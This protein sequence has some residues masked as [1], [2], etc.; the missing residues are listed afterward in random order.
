MSADRPL[1]GI[2]LMLCFCVLA[3]L[4]DSMAKLLGGTIPLGELIFFRFAVQGF[5]L[6]PLALLLGKSLRL[7]AKIYR[8]I[9]YRTVAHVVGLA[10]MF[11]AL[12]YLPLADAVAIAFV[13]PFFIL[14]SGWMFL[15]EEVGPHRLSACLVG[16]GGTLLVIQPNFTEVGWPAFLPLIVAIAFAAFMLT[17]RT[18]A[19]EVD[20]VTMQGI[21]GLMALPIVAVAI[22]LLRPAPVAEIIPPPRD[23]WWLLAAFGLV[24][25]FSHFFMTWSLKFAPA[26]TLAPMQYLEIPFSTF[27]GWL[28]FGDLPDGLAGLGIVILVS[29]GLYIIARERAIAVRPVPPAPPAS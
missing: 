12:Q 14:L 29:A 3:P 15:G 21:S 8:G 9:F 11:A 25:T 27:F 22:L 20:A 10:A 6:L 4:G 2:L 28:I 18:I 5:L 23:V 26:S 1:L 16:F 13:M 7:R 17:T 24:G 19:R